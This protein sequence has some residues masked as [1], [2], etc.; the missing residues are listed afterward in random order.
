MWKR[1]I[2]NKVVYFDLDKRYFKQ[3]SIEAKLDLQNDKD[4]GS[5]E[6][7]LWAQENRQKV[8]YTSWR[9]EKNSN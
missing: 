5:L 4:K 2:L 1:D 7:D 9:V 3:K 6:L 8:K